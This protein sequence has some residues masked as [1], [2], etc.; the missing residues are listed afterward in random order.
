MLPWC[1][2]LKL[3]M[4]L[5]H[6]TVEFWCGVRRSF[7]W[8]WRRCSIIKKHSAT[9]K[10]VLVNHRVEKFYQ[11]VFNYWSSRFF[12]FI[13]VSHLLRKLHFNNRSGICSTL[14]VRLE[15]RQFVSEGV[16]RLL[17]AE[18]VGARALNWIKESVTRGNPFFFC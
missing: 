18:G 8:L 3:Q 11:K 2:I 4:F 16:L 10:Y 12:S 9:H 6:A 5:Y 13:S 15:I 7:S 17:T 14:E 1:C